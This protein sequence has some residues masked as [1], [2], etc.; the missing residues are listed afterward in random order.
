MRQRLFLGKNRILQNKPVKTEGFP[1]MTM[2][3]REIAAQWVN[4]L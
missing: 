2:K 4:N 1:H 3:N